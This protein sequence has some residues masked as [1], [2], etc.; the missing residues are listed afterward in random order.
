MTGYGL[1]ILG[2]GPAGY[3]AAE[4]AAKKMRTL[5]IEKADLGG[6]QFVHA[7][8]SIYGVR[9]DSLFGGYW[10]SYIVGFKRIA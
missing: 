7:S 1:I 10:D 2:G 6:G 3:R 9:Y 4:L 5:L 8:S